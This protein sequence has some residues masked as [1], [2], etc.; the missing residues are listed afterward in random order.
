MLSGKA[1]ATGPEEASV[2]QLNSSLALSRNLQCS[3]LGHHLD[4]PTRAFLLLHGTL[5]IL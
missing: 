5:L 2:Q 4:P 3:I 1:A